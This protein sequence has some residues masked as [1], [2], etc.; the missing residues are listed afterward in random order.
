[1][2]RPLNDCVIVRW[3]PPEARPGALVI[4]SERV[5]VRTGIVTRVGPGKNQVVRSGRVGTVFVPTELRVGE[6]VAFFDAAAQHGKNR[7][8][9]YVLEDGEVLIHESDVLFVL[10]EKVSVVQ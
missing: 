3:D 2:I 9:A 4:P 5:S 1:M 10:E 6:R 7:L 8:P